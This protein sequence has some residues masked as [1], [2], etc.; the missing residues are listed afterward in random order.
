M[1]F[2]ASYDRDGGV[3]S[4]LG[5]GFTGQAQ[6]FISRF[7]GTNDGRPWELL[8]SIPAGFPT[9]IGYG[10]EE[11]QM[12]GH[13]AYAFANGEASLPVTFRVDRPGDPLHY[14][15]MV[16]VR[17]YILSLVVP[18]ISTAPED[19]V[20]LKMPYRPNLELDIDRPFNDRDPIRDHC[21]L[22][23]PLAEQVDDAD[24]DYNKVTY[25]VQ[26]LLVRRLGKKLTV[27]LKSLLRA[28]ELLV[29]GLSISPLPDLPEIHTVRVEPGQIIVPEQ[30][31]LSYD[32]S[33]VVFRCLTEQP[34]GLL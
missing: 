16:A 30:W 28:R 8:T 3:I 29:E 34:A 13:I 19:H 11:S 4:L 26:V 7:A 23:F 18:G 17:E 5:S 31:K 6:V 10:T 32:C 33:T 12:G 9:L 15:C 25:G 22:Y 20:I 14:K 21:V 1:I 2:Q 27:G 24:N